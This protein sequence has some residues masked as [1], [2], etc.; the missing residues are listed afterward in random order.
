MGKKKII[1]SSQTE[2]CFGV[3]RALT[4]AGDALKKRGTVYSLGPIIHNPQV[5]GEFEK[6]GLKIIKSIRDAG[7]GRG[8]LLIPSH[9]ISP[10]VLKRK[11]RLTFID[12][13]CPLVGRVQS[14]VRDLKKKGY[15]IIIVGDRKHPEVK[16]L[17]GIAGK[18][19][20]V[21][22]DRKEARELALPSAR[23]ALISQ[24]TASVMRFKEI[25]SEIAKKDF[26]E[27]AGFNTICKNTIDRQREA[28]RIAQKVEAMIVVGGR[29]SANTTKLARVCRKVNKNTRHIE[30]GRDLRGSFIRNK[31]MIGIATGAS[32]PPSAIREVIR[33][34]RRIE[35]R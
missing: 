23:I 6:K 3:R 15:C 31:R 28:R 13:T 35:C 11:K 30:S 18:D 10:D 16:G 9:G 26:K 5:V 19:S 34:I 22:K 21:L 29:N 25:L 2:F 27:L 14:I 12:T 32:T 1:V 20:R 8:A 7:P 17:V 24:T 33:K 4:I